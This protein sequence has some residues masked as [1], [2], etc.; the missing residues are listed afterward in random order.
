MKFK[1]YK[2]S[3][4]LVEAVVVVAIFAVIAAATGS[5]LF[6][7]SR[8][9]SRLADKAK[10]FQDATWAMDYMVNEARWGADFYLAP[11]PFENYDLITF[12][13]D[14]NHNRTDP[15]DPCVWYWRGFT[16][17][18]IPA[19][20]YGNSSILYR[21]LDA[22]CNTDNTTSLQAANAS[23]QELVGFIVDNPVNATGNPV[24]VF[25]WNNTTS[26][27]SVVLTTQNP[28]IHDNQTLKAK[29]VA[30][31]NVERAICQCSDGQDNDGD[32]GIDYLTEASE[33]C[34]LFF[35]YDDV[36]YGG[37]GFPNFRFDQTLDSI[38]P[39]NKFQD[40][41]FR[42]E[43]FKLWVDF[44]MF[45]T[46]GASTG[47]GYG[48]SGYAGPNFSSDADSF[49]HMD[50]LVRAPY[51]IQ[52]IP[53]STFYA[54]T[55]NSQT[56]LGIGSWLDLSTQ[57]A[58]N[59]WIFKDERRDKYRVSQVHS[60]R[61]ERAAAVVS[62]PNFSYSVPP[63]CETSPGGPCVANYYYNTYGNGGYIYVDNS[64]ELHIGYVISRTKYNY[65]CSAHPTFLVG[66]T[67]DSCTD[68]ACADGVDNDG[69]GF[70]DYPE[71]PGCASAKDISEVAHDLQCVD[72]NDMYEYK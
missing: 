14:T 42:N 28:S 52:G 24:R 21:G 34:G 22:A 55:I 20:N 2:L 58:G 31:N 40:F 23:R 53:E 30:L 19:V 8:S 39:G 48:S 7:A 72:A 54:N 9:G 15:N 64:G 1:K 3:V 62:A 49:I 18:A 63:W 36:R 45:S 61:A 65:L 29:V 46:L 37:T 57:P 44:R 38:L 11:V 56:M 47:Y 51:D 13:S 32:G 26:E 41:N 66:I 59:V 70:I 60:S 27:F 69:N 43:R 33:T 67:K 5:I 25:G 4:T 71:D 68:P 50:L 35:E 6:T 17:T 16:T 12:Q 10:V